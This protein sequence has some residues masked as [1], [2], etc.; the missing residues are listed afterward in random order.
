MVPLEKTVNKKKGQKTG[1]ELERVHEWIKSGL[2]VMIAISK[3]DG[4]MTHR[5][6]A[7][8]VDR[9]NNSSQHQVFLR[10]VEDES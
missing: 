3:L 7:E 8:F 10:A 1:T 9:I 2:R 4:T 5:P 6:F